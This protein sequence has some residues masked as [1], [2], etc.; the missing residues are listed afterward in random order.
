MK[1]I[2]TTLAGNNQDI[3][4][5]ALKSVVDWV[6]GCLVIDTGSDDDT[7]KTACAVA[8]RKFY[9]RKFTWTGDFSQ[10][11]N[12]ALES[13]QELG[14]DWAITL[15]TD[16]RI[17]LNGDDVRSILEDT[18][19][20]A[21]M[22]RHQSGAYVKERCI[23]LPSVERWAG[24]VHESFAAYKVGSEVLGRAYFTELQKTPAQ[25]KNKFERDAAILEGY[26]KAYP[27]NPRWFYYL[28]ESYKNLGQL[29]NAIVAYS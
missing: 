10:A 28:G 19:A 17:H 21:L 3:V 22:M 2:S 9:T 1:L 4:A 6:D 29:T 16:E 23:R 13:V 11:R 27:S 15:D 8:G 25:L 24:P 5:D 14:G 20:G 7:L 12:F 26:T 18:T